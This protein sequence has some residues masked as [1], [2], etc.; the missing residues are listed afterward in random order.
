MN[1]YEPYDASNASGYGAEPT[2]YPEVKNNRTEEDQD[3]L[4]SMVFFNGNRWTIGITVNP[5][6]TGRTG[7]RNC[8]H[9]CNYC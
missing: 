6:A 3:L 5:V 7:Y 4:S 9:L 1:Y 2:G 8:R